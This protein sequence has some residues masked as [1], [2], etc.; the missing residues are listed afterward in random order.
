MTISA[1]LIRLLSD[2]FPCQDVFNQ[3]GGESEELT[4]L[5]SRVPFVCT[6]INL[7]DVHIPETE[8]LILQ[9]IRITP[10]AFL[11]HFESEKFTL[12]YLTSLIT[13]HGE[14]SESWSN[15]SSSLA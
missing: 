15:G 10:A 7:S 1:Q 4:R 13:V 2:I 14:P 9:I 5:Y 12:L 6:Q 8:D 11:P 3:L